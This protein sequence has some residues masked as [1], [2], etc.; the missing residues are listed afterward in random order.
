[1]H[2]NGAYSSAT[3]LNALPKHSPWNSR[4][5]T[6]CRRSANLFVTAAGI[7]PAL[8]PTRALDLAR[9]DRPSRLAAAHLLG[10]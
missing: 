10:P 3:V 6:R 4:S 2:E 8:P 1:M 9:K 5:S 7:L